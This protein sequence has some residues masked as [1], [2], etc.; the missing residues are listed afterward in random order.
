[1]IMPNS[2]VFRAII[3]VLTISFSLLSCKKDKP[4]SNGDKEISEI[5]S[6]AYIYAYPLITMKITA[7]KSTNVAQTTD[8]G[9]A[10]FNQFSHRHKLPDYNFTS[11]VSPNVDTFYSSAWLD[12]DEEPMVLSVPDATLYNPEG[13]PWRYYLIQLMDAWSNVFAAPGV[14]TT[15]T[16]AGI[17]LISGPNWSGTVPGGMIHYSSPTNLVWLLGR[18][19]V[20]DSADIPT[21][22]AFQSGMSLMPLS[23]WPGPYDPPDGVV[24]DSI[25]MNTAPVN[26]VANLIVEKYFQLLCDLMVENP[27]APYDSAMVREMAKVGIAPGAKFRLSNFSESE[28]DAIED[29]YA[30]GQAELGTLKS[31][32]QGNSRNGWNYILQGMGAY[33][34][35][36]NTRAYIANIGLGANLPEDAVY[37]ATDIDN[38]N[39][40]LNTNHEYTMT[41][42]AGQTPPAQGFWSITMYNN[43]QFLVQNQIKRYAIGS[44]NDLQYNNDNSLTLYIQKN[45]PGGAKESNWLP[46]SEIDS[47]SF[48]LI[49]RIYWPGESVL[50]NQWEIPAVVRVN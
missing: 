26:Q 19:M 44:Y 43:Q 15:G 37:P 34:D 48:N 35:N 49:M 18:T 46:T 29:G 6:D 31:S 40:P 10:P 3:L 2:H 25:D 23:A 22:V 4:P 20:K 1:M 47:S 14:R 9:F 7:N 28:Q 21:V 27:A 12:L 36:Y 13:E 38:A 30:N 17:F 39:Q 33:G 16:G 41:F 32:I 45:N 24:N 50:N 42:P 5:I 11:V 8:L